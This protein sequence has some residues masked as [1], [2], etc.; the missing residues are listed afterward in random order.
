MVKPIFYAPDV[1]E[2]NPFQFDADN[3]FMT[4]GHF[5]EETS[6]KAIDD[7]LPKGL[8]FYDFAAYL[9]RSNN[10][11]DQYFSIQDLRFLYHPTGNRDSV[12]AI[13]A[14][15]KEMASINTDIQTFE[16]GM[17]AD[18]AAASDDGFIVFGNH[19]WAIEST[20]FDS[21]KKSEE[22]G[23]VGIDVVFAEPGAFAENQVPQNTE[24]YHDGTSTM[25]TNRFKK[26]RESCDVFYDPVVFVSRRRTSHTYVQLRLDTTETDVLLQAPLNTLPNDMPSHSQN[27]VCVAAVN[28]ARNYHPPSAHVRQSQL[29]F[30]SVSGSEP[31]ENILKGP[32]TFDSS[33]QL[34]LSPTV[35]NK[36]MKAPL[37]RSGF[38]QVYSN[39]TPTSSCSQHAMDD[40]IT[41]PPSFDL[42]NSTDILKLDDS[43][44][45]DCRWIQ[46]QL[47]GGYLQSI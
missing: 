27:A 9:H 4:T 43:G 31:E 26:V 46:E 5:K 22:N 23:H 38:H 17:A 35:I 28:D 2:Y 6:Y 20:R 45:V 32:P 13:P 44:S 1:D 40:A 33:E 39:C 16:R 19:A 3:C 10:E 34:Q 12:E 8:L 41:R 11:A 7:L 30:R 29:I 37:D 25:R 42:V 15:Q 21:V 47:F 18:V 14:E 24:T 36:L